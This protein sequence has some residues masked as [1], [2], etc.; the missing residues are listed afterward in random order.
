MRTARPHSPPANDEVE[1]RSLSDNDAA[2]G[3]AD[4]WVA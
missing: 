3:L 2:F 4:G 1:R